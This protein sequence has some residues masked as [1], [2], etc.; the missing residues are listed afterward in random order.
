LDVAAIKKQLQAHDDWKDAFEMQVFETNQLLIE[1]R[2]EQSTAST[3]EIAT[4]T[5]L[6]QEVNG[7][8]QVFAVTTR[9]LH[10]VDQRAHHRCKYRTIANAE[11]RM[12]VC[13]PNYWAAKWRQ[14]LYKH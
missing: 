2:R 12:C 4:L 10:H 6:A 9:L 14:T 13:R 7:L 8:I 11:T 5:S 3:A 1:Q